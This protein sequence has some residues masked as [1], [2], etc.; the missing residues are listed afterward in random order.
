M[1]DIYIVFLIIFLFVFFLSM[2]REKIRQPVKII[3]SKDSDV[4]FEFTPAVSLWDHLK[5]NLSRKKP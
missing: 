2:K 1:G 5:S 3:I 4:K